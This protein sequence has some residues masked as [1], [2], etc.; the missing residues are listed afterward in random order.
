MMGASQKAREDFIFYQNQLSEATRIAAM[1]VN[2]R[3]ILDDM[4]ERIKKLKA[5]YISKYG[6]E[7]VNAAFII[8]PYISPNPLLNKVGYLEERD[9]D[10]ELMKDLRN[11]IG[12]PDIPEELLRTIRHLHYE[13]EE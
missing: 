13:P 7:A 9:I 3:A 2:D 11:E 5:V 10:E 8:V 12:I 1:V 4:I 6:R